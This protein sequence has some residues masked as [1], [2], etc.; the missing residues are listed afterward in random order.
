MFRAN[1]P[2]WSRHAARQGLMGQDKGV[3]GSEVGTGW[4]WCVHGPH[5][6]Q[7]GLF[8]KQSQAGFM[9]SPGYAETGRGAGLE[10]R[11]HSGARDGISRSRRA[12]NG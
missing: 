10:S 8:M 6:S 3:K 11:G 7:I 9:N 1:D 5:R 4:G 12:W 2:I